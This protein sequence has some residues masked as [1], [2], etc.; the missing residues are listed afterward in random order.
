M[1]VH[2]RLSGWKHLSALES[3]KFIE[4]MAITVLG[5]IVKTVLS[6]DLKSTVYL[7]SGV[8]LRDIGHFVLHHR[9]DSS[10]DVQRGF[11][12]LNGRTQPTDDTVFVVENERGSL[13]GFAEFLGSSRR[14]ATSSGNFFFQLCRVH[15]WGSK[16]TIP[17]NEVIPGQ[18]FHSRPHS[19]Q[20][21][22]KSQ[23]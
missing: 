16:I 10:L 4:N 5:N 3:P 21:Q 7:D 19:R 12:F 18:R 20:F 13:Q 2:F 23:K 6:P 8:V 1:N 22:F 15:L 9:Q 17:C 14:L 11:R